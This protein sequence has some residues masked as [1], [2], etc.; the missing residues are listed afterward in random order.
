MYDYG[1]W[2]LEG[3]KYFGKKL[4]KNNEFLKILEINLISDMQLL[5]K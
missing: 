3:A 1:H 2:T 5:G 4:L